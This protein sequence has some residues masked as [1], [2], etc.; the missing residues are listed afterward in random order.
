MHRSEESTPFAPQ[1][2]PV[3]FDLLVLEDP[4]LSIAA[5]VSTR[6]AL[7]VSVRKQTA[8][9]ARTAVAPK[10][11]GS[12]MVLYSPSVVTRGAARP[13]RQA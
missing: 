7:R 6:G 3:T 10:L 13:P 8:I 5:I 4:H 9:L 11:T 12:R 2:F 1:L